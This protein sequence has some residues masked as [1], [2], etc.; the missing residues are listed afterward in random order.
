MLT[1]ITDVEVVG[2]RDGQGMVSTNQN[3]EPVAVDQSQALK[4]TLPISGSSPTPIV[5]RVLAHVHGDCTTDNSTNS[6]LLLWATAPRQQQHH[7]LCH[8]QVSRQQLSGSDAAGLKM[9]SAFCNDADTIDFCNA[10]S[11]CQMQY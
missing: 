5:Q 9:W 8:S 3:G 1:F 2:A 11:S 6:M 10:R 7:L 4:L